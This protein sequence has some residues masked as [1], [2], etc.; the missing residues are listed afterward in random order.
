MNGNEP[1]RC[2]QSMFIVLEHSLESLLLLLLFYFV[3]KRLLNF[4]QHPDSIIAYCARAKQRGL[5]HCDWS[6]K[7]TKRYLRQVAAYKD[8]VVYS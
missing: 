5:I 1:A 7:G 6:V 4:T 3:V 8:P 2:F